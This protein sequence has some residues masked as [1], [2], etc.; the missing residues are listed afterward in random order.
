M[1]SCGAQVAQDIRRLFSISRHL[2]QRRVDN[3]ALRLNN[4][5]YSFRLD[6]QG[7]PLEAMPEGEAYFMFGD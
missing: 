2:K 3:G 7:Q 1:P 5:K 4:L 6:A